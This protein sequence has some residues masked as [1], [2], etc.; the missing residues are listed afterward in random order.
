VEKDVANAPM[1]PLLTALCSLQAQRIDNADLMHEFFTQEAAPP[2]EVLR[3]NV[4]LKEK[5]VVVQAQI[6]EVQSVGI[7][8]YVSDIEEGRNDQ[9]HLNI[10]P[11]LPANRSYRLLPKS[12]RPA[13]VAQRLRR[14][15]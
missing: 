1:L 4:V 11:P 14:R 5:I 3:Q 9:D 13:T 15:V 12:E 6:Q 8:M 2:Q 7:A 10:S